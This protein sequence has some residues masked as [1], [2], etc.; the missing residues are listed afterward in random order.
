MNLIEQKRQELL[1]EKETLS[2]ELEN[3]IEGVKLRYKESLIKLDTKIEFATELLNEEQRANLPV[4]ENSIDENLSNRNKSIQNL[5]KPK[6]ELT[7]REGILKVLRDGNS[8]IS[9]D[10]L[11]P[12]MNEFGITSNRKTV[13]ARASKMVGKDIERIADGIYK[14]IEK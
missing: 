6:G 12:R 9:L 8:Q 10:E 11:M 4:S 7:V 3:E 14:L 5:F 1:I 2:Q 13:K